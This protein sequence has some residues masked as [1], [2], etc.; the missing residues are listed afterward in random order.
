MNAILDPRM[1]AASTMGP[2]VCEVE[3][4]ACMYGFS[5]SFRFVNEGRRQ[6]ADFAK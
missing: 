1:V 4:S 3:L 2:L 5:K 6:A